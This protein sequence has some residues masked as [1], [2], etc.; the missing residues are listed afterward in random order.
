MTNTIELFKNFQ[1]KIQI[2]CLDCDRRELI[3]LKVGDFFNLEG[4][5]I[6]KDI[7]E[8]FLCHQ[9]CPGCKNFIFVD[10]I[11]SFNP[12]FIRKIYDGIKNI[13]E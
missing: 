11:K 2:E 10:V 5:Y 9:L 4:Y 13:E 1:R 6:A 3:S 7:E 12:D 8:V